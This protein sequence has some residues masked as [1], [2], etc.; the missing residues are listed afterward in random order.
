MVLQNLLTLT[1]PVEIEKKEQRQI[2]W[3]ET[4]EPQRQ[5]EWHK[6]KLQR[7]DEWSDRIK[8]RLHRVD[9][10]KDGVDYTHLIP[11]HEAVRLVAF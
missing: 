3:H 6:T 4:K 7:Q 1:Q 2:E 5:I 9:S 11:Y 10:D 8:E